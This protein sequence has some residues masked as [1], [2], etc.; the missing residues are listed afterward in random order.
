MKAIS[1]W[2]PWAT[3][4]VLQIKRNETRSW[5][6]PHW[7]TGSVAIHAAKKKIN[8][9]AD[10]DDAEW[11]EGILKALNKAGIEYEDLTRGALIGVCDRIQSTPIHKR[12]KE[13][14]EEMLGD[15]SPGR[16]RWTPKNMRPIKQPIPFKGQQRLF[17]IDDNILINGSPD[18]PDRHE[19]L[20]LF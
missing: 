12:P 4:W 10:L 11:R 9:Y 20:K 1:L 18:Q 2:Q 3:L 13:E 19:Q 6:F 15:W 14:L 17:D 16:Y 7:Y 5:A 8:I